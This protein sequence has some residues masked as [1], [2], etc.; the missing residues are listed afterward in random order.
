[1]MVMNEVDDD[2]HEHEHDDDL[3]IRAAR[4]TSTNAIAP[5]FLTDSC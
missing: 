5:P 1:M 2:D 4:T 3:A